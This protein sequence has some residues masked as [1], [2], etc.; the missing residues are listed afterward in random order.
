MVEATRSC[1]RKATQTPTILL[2]PSDVIAVDPGKKS[3]KKI[4]NYKRVSKN[5]AIYDIG[6][7]TCE[8]YGKEIEKAGTIVWNGSTG[9]YEKEEFA[10]G[11]NYLLKRIS[12]SWAFSIL[13]GGDTLI[14]LKDE[15]LIQ[16]FSHFSTGGGARLEFLGKGTF[17]AIEAL[18]RNG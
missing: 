13:G 16:G 9:V 1:F 10:Q 14:A 12:G 15:K 4:V 17:P 18:K 11:T 3:K 7:K 5:Y 6:P 2:L 8:A